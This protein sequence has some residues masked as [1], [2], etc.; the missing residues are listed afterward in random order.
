MKTLFILLM[1]ALAS[2]AAAATDAQ[3]ANAG[4]TREQAQNDAEQTK[5]SAKDKKDAVTAEKKPAPGEYS[6]QYYTVNLPDGWKAIRAPED[7]QGVVNAIF[8]NNSGSTIITMIIGPRK[9][10]EPAMIAGMFADQFKAPK[11]PVEKNGRYTFTFPQND[12]ATQ[13][14]VTA[15]A[16]ITA[17]GDNFMLTSYIGSHKEAQIFFKNNLKFRDEYA[18]LM[19]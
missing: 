2:P 7:R 12:A 1:L 8:S 17:D 13:K 10:A 14:P 16:T 11:Q 5:E 3:N 15:T 9:G 19:P 4:N 18:K 6:C